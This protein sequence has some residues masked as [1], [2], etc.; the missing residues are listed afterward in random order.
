[1]GQEEMEGETHLED[2][3]ISIAAHKTGTVGGRVS[4]AE[5]EPSL[6]ITSSPMGLEVIS[7]FPPRRFPIHPS[8]DHP[9]PQWEDD[10]EAQSW[11]QVAEFHDA[12]PPSCRAA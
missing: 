2:Y 3:E 6:E 11:K 7:E 5:P 12:A 1:M 4:K 8:A 10:Q 9:K